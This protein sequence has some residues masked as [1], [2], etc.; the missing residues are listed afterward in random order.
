MINFIY[1]YTTK[2]G[3]LYIE[4]DFFFFK[5]GWQVKKELQLHDL[6]TEN[7]DTKLQEENKTCSSLAPGTIIISI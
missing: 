2:N 1:F 6:C 3:V 7:I 4:A 5:H